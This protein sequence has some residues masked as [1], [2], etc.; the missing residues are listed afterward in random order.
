MLDAVGGVNLANHIPQ[1]IDRTPWRERIVAAWRQKPIVW[2]AGP[3]RVGKTVLARQ[4]PQGFEP[5]GMLAFRERYPQGR[6]YVL[7]PVEGE[8]YRKTVKGLEVTFISPAQWP[9]SESLPLQG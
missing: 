5:R 4:L 8:S 6:Y 2:L 9:P 7:C 3:R 1:M